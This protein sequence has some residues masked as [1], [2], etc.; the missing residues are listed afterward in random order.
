[1]F[2]HRPHTVSPRG[3][4]FPLFVAIPGLATFA[5]SLRAQTPVCPPTT[6]AGSPSVLTG[7]YDNYRDAHNGNE[8]CLYSTAISGGT[9]TIA[10]ALFSPLLVDTPP[11]GFGLDGSSPIYAQPLYVPGITVQNPASGS[12]A[13]PR[14]EYKP[15][16]KRRIPYD[17]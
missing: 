14:W 5:V 7:Q 10:K 6:G 3:R 2:L 8:T 17:K 11:S 1:M 9:V 4:I 16:C 13:L 12:P 15:I